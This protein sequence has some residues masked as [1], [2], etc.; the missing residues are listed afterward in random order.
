MSRDGKDGMDRSAIG[1]EASLE[2]PACRTR[3]VSAALPSIRSVRP[4]PANRL[5]WSIRANR[6]IGAIGAIGA[7]RADSVDVAFRAARRLAAV[8]L[9]AAGFVG[10]ALAVQAADEVVWPDA[11][12]LVPDLPA[13]REVPA[14]EPLAGL[15]SPIP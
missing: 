9:A 2:E 6:S 10:G 8:L 3:R 12:H 1:A 11:P 13:P 5:V 14:P 15:P 4:V 7:I